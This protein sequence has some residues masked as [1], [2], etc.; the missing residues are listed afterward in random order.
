MNFTALT[1]G[2]SE[3]TWGVRLGCFLELTKPRISLLVLFSVAAAGFAATGTST[4]FWLIAGAVLGTGLIAI[5]GNIANQILEIG[6]DAKMARTA[7]R[8]LPS[9]RVSVADAF[10]LMTATGLIGTVYLAVFVNHLAAS[11]GV[12]TWLFY[13]AAYTP[14]KYRSS[15]NTAVGAIP[16]AI[17]VLIGW[18]AT[19]TPFDARC[20]SLFLIVFFWQFPHFMAIAWK[21]RDDYRAGGQ[22]MLTVTEP[23]GVAAGWLSVGTAMAL[24]PVSLWPVLEFGLA[25]P[26]SIAYLA[27]ATGLGLW[28]LRIAFRFLIAR[29][30][31]N[32]R[33]LLHASLIYLPLMLFLFTFLPR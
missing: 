15:W 4:N 20:A 25:E 28:Q 6:P 1:N 9:A 23:S 30:D 7:A 8:P 27:L 13:V 26:A 17:P 33:Q 10:W 22:K 2:M 14:M 12:L 29:N 3:N 24:L 18:A 21:Y 31:R 32:A 16:G 19:E 11:L 5:S